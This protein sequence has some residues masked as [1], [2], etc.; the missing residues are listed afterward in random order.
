MKSSSKR[1]DPMS[2]TRARR[3]ANTY[4]HSERASTRTNL[5]GNRAA[6]G[7]RRNDD[8]R[9][10]LGEALVEPEE[11][12]EAS[13]NRV[14]AIL[15]RE[16]L[17]SARAR[18]ELKRARALRAYVHCALV[19]NIGHHILEVFR[20]FLAVSNTSTPRNKRARNLECQ[21][22]IKDF[23]RLPRHD[24]GVVRSLE[25]RVISLFHFPFNRATLVP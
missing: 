15:I 7:Q 4:A 1:P 25:H 24:R 10:F 18:L 21:S 22:E 19:G 16:L 11:V 8:C 20:W 13:L 9:I 23:Q 17:L 5:A 2:P 14:V 6:L 12:I 3:T